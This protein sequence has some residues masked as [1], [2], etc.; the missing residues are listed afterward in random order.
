MQLKERE[1]ADAFPALSG[2]RLLT[3]VRVVDLSWLAA[4]PTG[5]LIL[6]LLGAEIIRIESFRALDHYRQG[7]EESG[8]PSSLFGV[9]NAGKKSVTI[10]LKSTEGRAVLMRLVD[11]A[12]LVVEN[13]SPGTMGRLQLSYEAMAERNPKLVMVSASAAGQDGPRSGFAGYAPIFAALAGLA[14]TA[15][16]DELH[17]TLFGRSVDARVGVAVAMAAVTGLL[18]RE[19]SGIGCHVDLSDQ[20]VCASLI[21]GVLT[22][23]SASGRDPALERNT[24]FGHAGEACYVC[25]DGT[26]WIMIEIGDEEEWR[27]LATLIGKDAADPVTLWK[28]RRKVETEVARWVA[29]HDP[30]DAL[31]VLQSAKVRAAK[32]QDARSLF[33]DGHLRTRKF[34]R[35][36]RRVDGNSE[37]VIGLPMKWI[38]VEDEVSPVRGAPGVGSDTEA[39]LTEVGYSKAEIVGLTASGVLR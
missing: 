28:N 18:A 12:D 5:T 16:Y 9:L 23:A 34:W 3:G 4:G 15:G 2:Q 27:R 13:F 21:G 6:G 19:R 38:G 29:L 22:R 17:P 30:D 33:E 10:N 32:V 24:S 35:T 1:G 8:Q 37:V 31:S 25:A 20:E 26:S 14:H 7:E 36:A 11:S 39:I